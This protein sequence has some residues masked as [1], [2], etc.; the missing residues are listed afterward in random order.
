MNSGSI[1]C[2]WSI[3]S[4]HFSF[5]VV[6]VVVVAAAAAAVVHICAHRQS[7]HRLQDFRT[8]IGVGEHTDYG[9]LTVLKQVRA[10]AIRNCERH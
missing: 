9:L 2:I 3:H 5:V 4:T 7:S 6:V 8:E 1:E 10:L